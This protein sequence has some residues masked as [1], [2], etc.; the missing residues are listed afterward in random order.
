MGEAFYFRGRKVFS[1]SVGNIS[2][3][4]TELEIL[5]MEQLCN[6]LEDKEASDAIDMEFYTFKSHLKRIFNKLSARNRTHAVVIYLRL[7][8]RLIDIHE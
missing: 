8:G 6:G 4:L 2:I 3:I 1:F 5:I 7:Q